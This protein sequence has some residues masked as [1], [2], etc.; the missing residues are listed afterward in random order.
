MGNRPA[1][2]KF[3]RNLLC[4]AELKSYKYLPNVALKE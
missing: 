1:K 2:A 3:C 4:L